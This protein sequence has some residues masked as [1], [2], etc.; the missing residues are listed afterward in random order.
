[1]HT[2]NLLVGARSETPTSSGMEKGEIG[3]NI[4]ATPIV[5]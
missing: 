4:R 1:M 3:K 2:T 5:L